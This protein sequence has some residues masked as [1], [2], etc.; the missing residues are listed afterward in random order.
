MSMLLLVLGLGVS[1]IGLAVVG[2]GIPVY[3]FSF[4]NTLILAGTTAFV[5]GLAVTGLAMVL[6]QLERVE[7]A[8]AIGAGSGRPPGRAKPADAPYDPGAPQPP[9]ARVEQQDRRLP[10]RAVPEPEGGHGM[11]RMPDMPQPP[12]EPPT[13]AVRIAPAIAAPSA[14][15]DAEPPPEQEPPTYAPIPAVPPDPDMGD[16]RRALSE[17]APPIE[18]PGETTPDG[19][20]LYAPS[21]RRASPAHK[22]GFDAIWPQRESAE[23]AEG[24]PAEPQASDA[25]GSDSGPPAGSESVALR[26]SREPQAATILKSGVIDGMAYTLYSDGS[27]EADTAHGI[28]RFGSVEELRAYLADKA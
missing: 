1:A 27:I 16:L 5:G 3:E 28:V 17:P 22:R 19:V 18:E 25:S 8:L 15:R 11:P 2:Y 6:R 24:Q 23:E 21:R 20:K 9:V 26:A 13:E 7:R 12:H 4:G 14:A 10:R